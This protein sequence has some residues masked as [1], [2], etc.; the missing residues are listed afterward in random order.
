MRR[1]SRL[2]IQEREYLDYAG[3]YASAFEFLCGLFPTQWPL[4][5]SGPI[6]FMTRFPIYIFLYVRLGL[7]TLGPVCMSRLY[8][9]FCA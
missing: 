8:F 6:F 4:P 7:I 3:T 9:I 5:M 2:E 1:R